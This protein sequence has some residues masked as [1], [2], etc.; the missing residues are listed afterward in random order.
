MSVGS[1]VPPLPGGSGV[2][3]CHVSPG[4]SPRTR[5]VEPNRVRPDLLGTRHS[6]RITTTIPTAVELGF[7]PDAFAHG[8][9]ERVGVDAF[10]DALD[11]WYTLIR[12]IADD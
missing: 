3:L 6:R 8:L 4:P 5:Q 9:D 11:Y 2:Q 1:V 10:D 12:S 7:D